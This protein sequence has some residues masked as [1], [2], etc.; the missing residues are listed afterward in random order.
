MNLLTTAQ[1]AELAGVT[2]GGFRATA[3][4]ARKKGVEL[5]APDDQ[6]PDK[7]TPMYD[8]DKLVAWLASRPGRGNRSPR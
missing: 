1:A 3:N 4:W 8:K 2:P 7:R 5:R 6:W